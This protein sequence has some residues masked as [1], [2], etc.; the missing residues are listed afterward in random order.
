MDALNDFRI[1]IIDDNP[2]IHSDFIKILTSQHEKS[3]KL[4][5]LQTTLFGKNTTETDDLLPRFQIDTASQGKEGVDKIREAVENGAP[6]SLAFVD[7]RMPP[8]WDGIET[9]KHIWEVNKDIQIVICTAYSDYSWEDTIRE[10][11]QN[12][13]LLILKKP[14]DFTSVRQLACALT[15]KWKLMQEART[16]THSLEATV[17]KRTQKLHYLATHDELTQLP[18][19]VLLHDKINE[20]ISEAE[21]HKSTFSV[22]FFDLDRFKLINDS[23]S[24][25]AGDELLRT[26]AERLG[27]RLRTSD[28]L[29][30]IGGDEFV[31]IINHIGSSSDVGKL[32]NELLETVRQPLEIDGHSLITTSSVGISN[33]PAD[34]KDIDI[35]IRNADA[36][37]YYSKKMGGDRFQF[38]KSIMNEDSLKKLQMESE[39]R[40]ATIDNQFFLCYQP[41]YAVQE[42]SLVAVEALIRWQHPKKG[43]VLPV[44]FIPLAEEIGLIVPIGEWVLRQA[45]K[46]NKLWQQ[47]GLPPIR[48]AVNVTTQQLRDIS[49]VDT[50]SDILKETNLSPEYLELE[51]SENSII[52]NPTAVSVIQSLKDIG[53][54]IAVDDFGTGYSSL[55]Y[56]R[57]LPLDRIKIDRSFISNI[58]LNHGDEVI[59]QAIIAMAKGLKLEVM[60]EGVENKKQLNFLKA[61]NCK[62]IQGFYFSQPLL[63]N[64]L[65]SILKKGSTKDSSEKLGSQ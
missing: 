12:D 48:V 55:N 39:L 60:A 41:Q 4:E 7:I 34:G 59:I 52:N 29:A 21:K 50:V 24:H 10:L 49:F 15:R 30:R 40:Q 57:N 44:D 38:Y 14:F 8:G 19:R 42:N 43:V 6:Y 37:M 1:L 33:Y 61:E 32:A 47:S 2:Q 51:L 63:A 31:M 28:T 45:C 54:K 25:A 58:K 65:E 36:A 16:Y 17:K 9:I 11:G 35:L 22:L 3:D 53:V 27:S 23:L 56:I 26:V 46:Q 62:E 5:E 20:A 13:N 18:N 64:E